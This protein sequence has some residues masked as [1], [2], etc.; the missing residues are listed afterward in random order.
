MSVAFRKPGKHLLA[1]SN[2]REGW[3]RKRWLARHTAWLDRTA[4]LIR[5]RMAANQIAYFE[6]KDAR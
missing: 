2:V 5:E 3:Q 6:R 1:P 4:D